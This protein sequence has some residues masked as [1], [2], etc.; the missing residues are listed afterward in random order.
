M[1]KKPEEQEKRW[2]MKKT[3]LMAL[4]NRLTAILQLLPIPNAK[5]TKEP[6]EQIVASRICPTCGETYVLADPEWD[7]FNKKY[8][9]TH[10]HYK[11]QVK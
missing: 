3:L 4:L 6:R 2:D 11:C 9:Y 10:A 1:R 8:W 5:N 7:D